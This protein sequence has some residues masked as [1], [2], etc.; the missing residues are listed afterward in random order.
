MNWGWEDVRCI[1]LSSLQYLLNLLS[2][3]NI[4]WSLVLGVPDNDA[5]DTLYLHYIAPHELRFSLRGQ[6]AQEKEDQRVKKTEI[7]L[8]FDHRMVVL[9][10]F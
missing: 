10:C 3:W 8:N 6:S 1:I 5:G 9:E 4:E 7:I 2:H